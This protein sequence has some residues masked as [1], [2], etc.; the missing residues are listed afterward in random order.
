MILLTFEL[1]WLA[2]ADLRRF[3]SP[4]SSLWEWSGAGVGWCPG[5]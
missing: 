2:D 5:D 3:V 1:G 4:E